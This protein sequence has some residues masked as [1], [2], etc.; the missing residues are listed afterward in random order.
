ML[1]CEP[2]SID[3]EPSEELADLDLAS[4]DLS[5][6][7]LDWDLSTTTFEVGLSDKTRLSAL[8]DQIVSEV[9]SEGEKG[10]E[11]FEMEVSADQT[12]LHFGGDGPTTQKARGCNAEGWT[13]VAADDGLC[14]TES[15]VRDRLETAFEEAGKPGVGQCVDTR[16]HR[17]LTGASVCWKKSKC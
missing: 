10:P 3:I 7:E 9:F 8:T 5:E 17:S 16:V 13:T 4:M 14:R 11:W 2:T 6:M 12:I 1:S 15:C